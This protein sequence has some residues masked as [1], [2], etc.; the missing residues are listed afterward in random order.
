MSLKD[1]DKRIDRELYAVEDAYA[2]SRRC[3]A[4]GRMDGDFVENFWDAPLMAMGPTHLCEFHRVA[5]RL[6]RYELGEQGLLE[7]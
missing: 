2:D 4:C 3:I 1:I 6:L 5:L 7:F